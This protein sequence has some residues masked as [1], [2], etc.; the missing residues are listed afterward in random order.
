MTLQPLLPPGL[1]SAVFFPLETL[2]DNQKEFI[3]VLRS[4]FQRSP[5][6]VSVVLATRFRN[7]F[8]WEGEG[9]G[10]P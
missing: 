3:R 6:H 2:R 5:H 1:I 7:E 8:W 10:S 4:V 9:E